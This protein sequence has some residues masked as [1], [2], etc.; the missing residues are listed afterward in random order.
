MSRWRRKVKFVG[1]EK[2]ILAVIRANGRATLLARERRCPV[3][4]S[5]VISAVRVPS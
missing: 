3:S 5:I 4:G 2:L 1:D